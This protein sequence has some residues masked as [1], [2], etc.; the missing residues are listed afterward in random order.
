MKHAIVC[1]VLLLLCLPAAGQTR[2]LKPRAGAGE[3]PA[4]RRLKSFTIGAEQ[5][6]NV[7]VAHTFA[8]DLDHRYI[9]VEVG[10]YPAPAETP[11]IAAADFMLKPMGTKQVIRPASPQTIA[12]VLHRKPTSAREVT[13]YPAGSVGYETGSRDPYG[14]RYPGG[15]NTSVGVGVGIDKKEKG[16]TDADRQVIAT[17]L[18]DKAL[19]EGE[20]KQP[21]AGYLYFPVATKAS[22]TVVSY[23]LEWVVKGQTVRLPLATPSE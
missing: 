6:S 17:E 12:E 7:E 8:A 10:I 1:S 9:V 18:R 13:L 2:G 11:T 16:A 23:E 20:A 3:Y 22:K 19:P 14:N 4:S 15:M 21:I 5:L